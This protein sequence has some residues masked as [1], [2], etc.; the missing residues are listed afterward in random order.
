[1]SF[2]PFATVVVLALAVA[3]APFAR[4]DAEEQAATCAVASQTCIDSCARFG[5]EDVRAVACENVCRRQASST[6]SAACPG[7]PTH[8]E[9]APQGPVPEV[10]AY[11]KKGDALRERELN[12]KM[13]TAISQGNLR[14]VRRLLE[15][16]KGLNPTYV[17]DFDFNPETR[18]Y[19]GRAVKLRLTDVF[20]DTNTVRRDAEGLDKILVLL[21]ELGLDVNATLPRARSTDETAAAI[22]PPEHT[23]WG[24]SL[25]FMEK[26]RDRGARLRAFEIALEKGLEPNEDVSEWLF[27]ELPEVCGRDR[28]EF[29]IQVVDLLIEHLGT[30]LQ[31]DF[32]RLGERGP[33]S[34]SDVLDRLMSP[35]RTPR[36]SYERTEFAMMDAVWENCAPLSRR[37]NRYLTQGN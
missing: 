26:A 30:S 18:L 12:G 36:S 17:Y 20:N 24:P 15:M 33:E 9:P 34:V 5:K 22:T 2:N 13:L 10:R 4:A 19:E 16:K 32:W 21:I 37:I 29:A 11:S 14:D 8:A 28:S 27:A 31:D 6:Q 1:M 7:A 23:A 25:K 3:I 35:G